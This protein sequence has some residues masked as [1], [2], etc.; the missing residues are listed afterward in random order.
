[1][2]SS[3]PKD[4]HRT[5][6]SAFLEK[7]LWKGKWALT[8]P[9]QGTG[10]ETYYARSEG[11]SLFVKLGA[12]IERYQVISALG[13]CPRVIEVGTLEDG[14][15]ILIQ[16]KIDARRP[17]RQDFH[18]HL[19]RFA[20]IIGKTHRCEEL[21]RVLP[22]RGSNSYKTVALDM[23]SEI[24]VRWNQHKSKAPTA[25]GFIDESISRLSAHIQQFRDCGLVASH[26]DICNANWL[27]TDEG[28]IYL[29]DFESMSQD[30]PALDLGAFLWWYYPPKFYPEF[31]K[32]AGYENDD[33]F[34]QRMRI[35][36]AVHC[37]NI[38]L[39]R[40]N[41][42]DIFKTETFEDFLEDFRAVMAG[43]ENPKRYAD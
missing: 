23:L 39:P 1:M 21:K 3:S 30:D 37:L 32:I 34:R 38:M 25:A 36:L 4:P 26:N 5:E 20:E 7:V 27:V 15:T 35:R 24:I 43:Q 17:S 6:V 18:I 40:E 9:Y 12:Q 8:I 14:T 11:H 28:N 10:H 22:D 42:F 29:I 2:T 13:L 33:L 31:L 41:S 16:K 19:S